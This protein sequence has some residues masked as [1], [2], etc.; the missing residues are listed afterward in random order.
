MRFSKK[1]RRSLL[2]AA[3]VAL[4]AGVTAGVDFSDTPWPVP[5]DA[6]AETNPIRY[7]VESVQ[8]GKALFAEHCL[9]CHGYWGEGNGVVGLSLDDRP[10]NLLRLAGKQ[11][12]GAFA[13]KI[14]TGR[15]AMP[16]FS[17]T[18]SRDDIWH[19]VNFVESLENELGSETP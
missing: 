16:G 9:H 15:G 6:D 1:S 2:V 18:V 4:S 13:W 5:A 12:E 17:D 10:A 14:A 11:S 8:R 19:M 3:G 7:D